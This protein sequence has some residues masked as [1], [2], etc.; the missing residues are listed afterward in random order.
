M[1]YTYNISVMCYHKDIKNDTIQYP[2]RI[3]SCV[4]SMEGYHNSQ[5]SG[6]YEQLV[7]T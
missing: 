3:R 1:M 5:F 4:F 2:S 6:P 7:W